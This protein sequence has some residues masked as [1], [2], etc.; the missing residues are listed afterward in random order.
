MVELGAVRVAV[1][2]DVIFTK[3]IAIG[4]EINDEEEG[5]QDR[6]LGHT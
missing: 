3:D 4:K 1:E 2:I 6:A 5:P